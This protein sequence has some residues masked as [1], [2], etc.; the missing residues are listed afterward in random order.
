MTS[1]LAAQLSTARET[2]P[3]GSAIYPAAAPPP[4]RTLVDIFQFTAAAHPNAPALD[5]GTGTLSYAALAAEVDEVVTMWRAAGLGLGDRIGIRIPSGTAELYVS[6]LATLSIGAAYVPVDFDDPAERAETIWREAEVSA[7]A[8]PGGEIRMLREPRRRPIRPPSP[9]NDA[10]IIFTSGST[11]KPKGVAVTHRSAAAFVD[12]EAELFLPDDP[13]GPADRV[14]A[15]LSV[16]F[17]ASCEEMWLAWRHGACLVPAPRELVRAGAELGRWLVERGITVVSTVPTLAAL[18]PVDVLGGV[19]LVILG[20]EATSRELAAKLDLPGREVWNTYGPTETTVVAS[21]ARVSADLPVR[22]GYPLTGWQLAVVGPNGEPVS[23]G[24]TGELVI[25]GVGLARYLDPDKDREKFAP[26]PSLGWERAYRSGDVV[27]AD[28]EGLIFVGRADDQVKI[29]GRRVELGEVDAALAALPGVSA[30]ASVVRKTE[31]GAPVLVGYLALSAPESTLDVAGARQKLAEHLPAALVPVLAV[32]PTLP[33]RASGKVDR[34]ALP[35]PLEADSAA[36]WSGAE[37]IIA[38]NWTAVLGQAPA[39]DS[40]FFSAGGGSLAVAHLVSRLR[41][42]YPHASVADIYQHPTVRGLAEKL[43]DA[44]TT[45]AV[46]TEPKSAT[47][48]S[49]ALFGLAQS[50]FALAVFAF[51]GLRTLLVVVAFHEV[52]ALAA[53]PG[54]TSIVPWYAVAVAWLLLFTSPGRVMLSATGARVATVG[55]RPGKHR[56]AGWNHLRLWAA[57]R[58]VTAVGVAS[59]TGT[60][61]VRFYARALGCRVGRHVDLHALPPVTGLATFGDR[62]AVEPDSDLAGWWLDSDCVRVGRVEVGAG[63]RI[64]SH[65][66]LMDG[67]IVEDDAEV[68]SGSSVRGTVPSGRRWGGAPARDLGDR[69]GGWPDGPAR[70]S[71]L[72]RTIYGLT[73]LLTG[74]IML[75]AAFPGFLVLGSL[76]TNAMTV[77][78][79]AWAIPLATLTSLA[80]YAGSTVLVVRLLNF[81][82]KPGAHLVDSLTGWC[83][84]LVQRLTT[85][86]RGT[87]FALY[88]GL[89]T[90]TWL[91][92]LG[93]RIGRG[94][95]VS[96]VTGLPS[97]MTVGSGS[98][99]ADDTSLAPYELRNGWLL[100]G[101]A[102]VGDRTFIGNSAEVA[103]DRWVPDGALIGVLSSAPERVPENTSWLGRPAMLLPRKPEGGS[104]ARTYEPPRRLVVARM[105]IE[106][107]RLVPVMVSYGLTVFTVALLSFLLT[108]Q[109]VVA[110]VLTACWL[111]PVIALIA[112]VVATAAKWLLVGKH[113]PRERPLWSSFVWRNELAAVFFEELVTRWAGTAL[114]G[115]PVFSFVLRGMGAKI[116]RG[117]HCETRWLPEPDL[118]TLGDGAVVN[119]GCV[120]QTH[121]FHDRIMRLGPIRIGRNAT[122]AP[123]SVVLFDST[124]GAGGSVWA[125]SLVMR[126]E[127]LPDGTAWAGI[128]VAAQTGVAPR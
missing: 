45:Q 52:G 28:P 96:T 30:A 122:I 27:R 71:L 38:E 80:T 108:S 33:V 87:L 62:A 47:P 113:V 89:L 65:T 112:I 12:A 127:A 74:V 70:R 54:I 117:V 4:Q 85:G 59:V 60:F 76:I 101:T 29:G 42:H 67:A 14:L 125:N 104:A 18:W 88:A 3:R 90:S 37:A 13:L 102:R 23:W 79:A 120:V 61:W 100:I 128:P 50:L 43:T 17:D 73:P 58:W 72:W 110:A 105:L 92:M 118:V 35:W 78:T 69:R 116:G 75:L 57:E 93:A 119:R 95:E 16:G 115:T 8:G 126:G 55:I 77:A 106:T 124:V 36:E 2:A 11:G 123:R 9:D 98:F 46:K 19:R 82:V 22:I 97:M 1:G 56:R 31:T 40:D 25:G 34:D 20:G 48:G 24:G 84:W 109:G 94:T 68:L 107:C 21:A 91:R 66:T 26:L 81:A 64:G 53:V 103:R 111:M 5:A 7:I 10:W 32:L 39:E 15:G 49:F 41:E 44:S 83:A 86:A 51:A 99:L 6:I 63:S 114:I 121:L